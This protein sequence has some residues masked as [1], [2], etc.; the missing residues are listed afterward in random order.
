MAK[1][2]RVGEDKAVEIKPKSG[3]KFKLAEV[4]ALVGGY[5]EVIS[6][7]STDKQTVLADEEALVK[8][9]LPNRNFFNNGPLNAR[10]LGYLLYGD[11]LVVG[12][13]EFD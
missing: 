9:K 8:F 7:M 1:L 4:Q 3:R 12:A 10:G 5:V 11:V 6:A 2:Y 13:N